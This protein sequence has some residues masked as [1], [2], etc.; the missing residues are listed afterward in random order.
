MI[1]IS[2]GI[3]RPSRSTLNK[4][5]LAEEAEPSE[6]VRHHRADQQG[7]RRDGDGHDELS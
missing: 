6:A 5:F 7:R 1:S 2:G 4:Q 3:M